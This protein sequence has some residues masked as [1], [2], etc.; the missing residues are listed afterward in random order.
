M[1]TLIAILT[2]FMLAACKHPELI[3]V[4][5]IFKTEKLE[6]DIECKYSSLNIGIRIDF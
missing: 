5:P 1:K 3:R 2:C 6:K 4:K